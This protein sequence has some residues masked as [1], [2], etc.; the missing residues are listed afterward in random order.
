[1]F[2]SSCPLFGILIRWYLV[3][4]YFIFLHIV[5]VSHAFFIRAD[6]KRFTWTFLLIQ[7]DT[8]ALHS[9]CIESP[10]SVEWDSKQ[11]IPTKFGLFSL[12]KNNL[13]SM[14]S[15]KLYS[16]LKSYIASFII[17]TEVH[18]NNTPECSHA[19]LTFFFFLEDRTRTCQAYFS[20]LTCLGH[21]SNNFPMKNEWPVDVILSIYS[22]FYFYC[23]R[24]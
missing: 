11:P 8:P 10:W 18:E 7:S 2:P 23:F 17:L 20:A 24:K 22:H 5:R 19:F 15:S 16:C 9:T 21:I 14:V 6:Y 12:L 4:K 3:L 13:S 1:M